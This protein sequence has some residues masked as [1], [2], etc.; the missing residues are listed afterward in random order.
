MHICVLGF[1]DWK[2]QIIRKSPLQKQGILVLGLGDRSLSVANAP[3]NAVFM[4][5]RGTF[6]RIKSAQFFYIY[7]LRNSNSLSII[8]KM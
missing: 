4:P 3:R 1:M 8:D 7:F 5:V 2:E 6:F